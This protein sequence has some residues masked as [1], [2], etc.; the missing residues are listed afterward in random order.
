LI[1]NAVL[2]DAKH[3]AW[4]K[5]TYRLLQEAGCYAAVY[6]NFIGSADDAAD[7]HRI[8]K[9][10]GPNLERLRQLKAKYD[11]G[12]FFSHNINVARPGTNNTI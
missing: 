12:N 3:V 11:P 7:A 4:T 9:A 8:S 2:L 6:S 1:F 5:E 10:F